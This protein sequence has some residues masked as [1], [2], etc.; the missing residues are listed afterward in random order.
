MGR[1]VVYNYPP[2]RVVSLVPSLTELLMDLG[3]PLVGRTKFCVHPSEGL[4]SISSVGGTKDFKTQKVLALKPDLV[5]GNKE[6]NYREGIEALDR[7][8][9]P[10]WMTD[11]NS[12]ADCLATL[13]ELGGI[14][15][16]VQ[17]GGEIQESMR[18]RL[19]ELKH[20]KSGKVL[21]L[22]WYKPWMAAGPQTYIHEFLHHLGYHNVL[23]ASRYP[24]L[25]LDQIKAL[26]AEKILF[27]SEPFP[28]REKHI[29]ELQN[30]L[31]EVEMKMVDGEAYSWYGSRLLKVG[32]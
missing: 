3:V 9:V 24:E 19:A 31:P 10:V 16:T 25:T 12:I 11:I 29:E 7:E 2:R 26:R 21:Y 13:K 18:K 20:T 14:T 22:I 30:A 4:Q 1:E 17:K 6:E 28:F 5:I 15:G 23:E 32:V 27:S 8:Q